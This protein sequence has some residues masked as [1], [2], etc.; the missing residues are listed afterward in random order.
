MPRPARFSRLPLPTRPRALLTS[1]PVLFVLLGAALAGTL[2]STTGCATSGVNQG[3]IN[4]LSY[5][6]EWQ[7]GDRLSKDLAGKLHLVK[8]R[9][10]LAYVDRVGQRLVAQ[11]ELHGLPWHFHIVADPEVNA[12][13]IPGGHVY[14][15]TGLIAAAGDVAEFSGVMAHEIGH[16]VARHGTEQLTRAYGL[17]ILSSMVLGKSPPAY[18]QILAQVAGTGAMARFSRDAEDEADSLG[19]RYMAAAGY[20]PKGM[21]DMFRVLLQRRKSRPGTVGQFFSTHPL[22]EE[23]IQHVDALAAQ[24]DRSGLTRHDKGYQ[25]LHDRFAE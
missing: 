23:R 6:E 21:G 20:D 12:F 9:A 10:A 24:I 11:T 4:V 2:A 5:Q 22:T 19:V 17:Q 13:N 16:G 25:R 15:N 3:D 8:N 14:V 18:Q 7:L 1:L